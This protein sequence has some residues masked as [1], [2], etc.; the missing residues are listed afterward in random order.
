M[1]QTTNQ[2]VSTNTV[3]LYM[4]K[5]SDPQKQHMLVIREMQMKSHIKVRSP[6]SELL[7]KPVKQIY[8]CIPQKT[9]R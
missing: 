7:Y 6:S 4:N 2:S 8:N 1:F 9:K 5:L 3:F